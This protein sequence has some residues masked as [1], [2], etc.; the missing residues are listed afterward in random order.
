MRASELKDS[1]G[2]KQTDLHLLRFLPFLMA[3]ETQI[4]VYQV[5]FRSQIVIPIIELEKCL[6][7][8]LGGENFKYHW[9]CRNL[10]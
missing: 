10:P 7:H 9:F 8:H 5:L 1:Y 6:A 3:L 4:L 2:R